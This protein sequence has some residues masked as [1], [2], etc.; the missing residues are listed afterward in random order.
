MSKYT[1]SRSSWVYKFVFGEQKGW[2][3]NGHPEPRNDRISLGLFVGLFA[4]MLIMRPIAFVMMTFF[5]FGIFAISFLIDGSYSRGK[6]PT[7]LEIVKIEPWPKIF[8]YRFPPWTLLMATIVGSTFYYNGLWEGAEVTFYCVVIVLI[9]RS[10]TPESRSPS[11]ELAEA[12]EPVVDEK[13]RLA[14]YREPKLF[15]ALHLVD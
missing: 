5:E 14:Y 1:L 12:I 15:P 8:G 10:I 3:L 11:V 13:L 6:Y 2:R 7:E 9:F 4:F